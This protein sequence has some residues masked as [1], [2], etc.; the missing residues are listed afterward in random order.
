MVSYG[1]YT[2]KMVRRLW[3]V[4]ALKNWLFLH[5]LL[6]TDYR[7]AG[8]CC[9]CCETESGK[10]T[11]S[12]LATHDQLNISRSLRIV[13]PSRQTL[14]TAVADSNSAVSDVLEFWS[15]VIHAN[16]FSV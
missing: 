1:I 12:A 14:A 6:S 13:G 11:L 3:E 16:Q 9:C 5:F 15:H 7:C 8:L 2:L 4:T 10:G